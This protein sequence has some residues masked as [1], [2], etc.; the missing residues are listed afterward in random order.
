MGGPIPLISELKEIAYDHGAELE[1]ATY[2]EQT[3]PAPL[4]ILTVGTKIV[5]DDDR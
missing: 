3:Q 2:V 1:I 4:T 5:V